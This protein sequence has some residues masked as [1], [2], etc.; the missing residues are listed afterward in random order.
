[1]SDSHLFKII[2][3][4]RKS[5][6]VV[7]RPDGTVEVRAPKYIPEFAINMFVKSKSDWIKERQ[8]FLKKHRKVAKTFE[9][10]ERIV[11]LG[12]S[13]ILELGNYTQVEVKGEKLKFPIA[14]KTRGKETIE[15]WYIKQA[16]SVIRS[17]LDFY[18]NKMNLP[19]KSVNFSDTSSKWGSCTHDNRLQFNWRLIMAPMI[20]I[21]YVIIH[22]LTHTIHKNHSVVFWGMVSD[23]NPSYKQQIKWLKIHGESL[24]I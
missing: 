4:R 20:V 12:E 8:S 1:M 21:R 13:Y 23:N 15:K 16:K 7:V 14:L 3:S 5:I 22:E 9:N 11:Y 17:Q 2:R 18:S 24:H 6:A 19:Y 10:G